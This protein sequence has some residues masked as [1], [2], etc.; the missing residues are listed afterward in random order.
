MAVDESEIASPTSPNGESLTVMAR[1]PDDSRRARS[2]RKTKLKGDSSKRVKM[3]LPGSLS[4]LHRKTTHLFGGN[5][6]LQ[7]YHHGE[8]PLTEPDHYYNVQHEDVIV[9]TWVGHKKAPGGLLTS[10]HRADYVEHP[11]QRRPKTTPAPPLARTPLDSTTSYSHDYCGKSFTHREPIV[12]PRPQWIPRQGT[13]GQSSYNDD[14]PVWETVKPKR[15]QTP[16]T[17]VFTN[18]PCVKDSIYMHDYLAPSTDHA[19]GK[20][21]SRGQPFPKAPFIGDTTY[22]SDFLT[23]VQRPASSCRPCTAQLVLGRPLNERSEY[24]TKYTN[25][26]EHAPRPIV[27]VEPE[28]GKLPH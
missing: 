21:P 11:L 16:S 8:V 7:L 6:A 24:A 28:L 2:A 22:T 10:T 14:Y 20:P 3:P 25:K 26:H 5:G 23:P 27:H 19:T 18:A 15:A 13:T 17:W 9:A 12:K 4:E 1:N